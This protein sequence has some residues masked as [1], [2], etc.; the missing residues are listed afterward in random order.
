MKAITNFLLITIIISGCFSGCS[1]EAHVSLNKADEAFA[2]I[3][4]IELKRTDVKKPKAEILFNYLPKT[5]L[6]KSKFEKLPNW[7]NENYTLALESFINSCRSIKTKNIYRELC[8]KASMSLNPKYFL[9]NEFEPYEIN[10][11]DG[12]DEGLLT[13][14]YEP[15]LKG[16]LI[17]E[18]P[19]IYPINKTPKDLIIVDLSSIYPG[20]KHY[21]LRGR[22]EGSKLVPYYTRKETRSK[23]IESGV[24]C[25][26]D[27]KLDRFFLEIQGSGRIS[28]DNGETIFVGYD[29]QNGH[30]YRAIGKYLVKKGELKMKEVS[31]QSI[32]KWL[33]ENPKRVDEVLNYNKSVVYFKEKSQ[34]AS[35]SLGLKLTPKRSIAVDRRYI[36]LG[37]MLYLNADFKENNFS[38]VVVAQDTG[39]A[40]KGAI[41]ADMFLG[42]GKEARE[43]A[44]ELKS[45]LKLW[46]LLPKNKDEQNI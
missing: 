35:G 42:Y 1:K 39:G 22:V 19:Y 21:R 3:K 23:H 34:G 8:K 25:Y 4:K 16:S 5:H 12:K 9:Q 26:T 44:G 10:S 18:Y 45:P 30:Q 43:V 11:K 15:L 41:R 36:P 38:S 17:K 29:N 33:K 32:R 13:G 28:L 40:I 14:Y 24:I 20:L 2:E 46:I 27:S 37:S 6:L 7:S 31:L